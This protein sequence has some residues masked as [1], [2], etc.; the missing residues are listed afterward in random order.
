MSINDHYD[1]AEEPVKPKHRNGKPQPASMSMFEWAMELERG[2]GD[3]RRETLDRTYTGE[4]AANSAAASLV[5]HVSRP[6]A[7][8]NGLS[9]CAKPR[10][11]AFLVA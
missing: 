10:M 3:G 2:E 1:D 9:L 4:A 6:F 5:P 7:F 8:Q 11:Q